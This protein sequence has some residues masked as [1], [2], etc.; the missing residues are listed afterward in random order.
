[1]VIVCLLLSCVGASKPEED[2]LK[3]QALV[4]VIFHCNYVHFFFFS[5]VVS[6]FRSKSTIKYQ[7]C[8]EFDSSNL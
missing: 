5:H 6:D 3:G 8:A 2:I 4:G 7:S 1:M